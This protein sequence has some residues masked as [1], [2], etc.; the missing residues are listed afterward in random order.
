MKTTKYFII[1]IIAIVCLDQVA[2][3]TLNY[4]HSKTYTGMS[5]GKVNYLIDKFT[6]MPVLA[7]G[8]SRCAHHVIPKV[9]GNER[10]YNLSH[11]GMN[12]IFHAGIIDQLL[13]NEKLKIDTILLHLE[14]NEMFNLSDIKSR[15]IQHLKHYYNDNEWIRN[16][17]T[18][19]SDFEAVKYLLSSYK[20]NG[21]IVSIIMNTIKTQFI[22]PPKD[23][24]VAKPSTKR[25]SINVSW[26]FKTRIFFN[27]NVDINPQFNLHISHIKELCENN[28][29]KL[30]CFMSPNY[31]PN[32]KL[33][34]L[35]KEYKKQFF[36]NLNIVFY[37]YSEEYYTNY[38]LR[39]IWNWTD[40]DHLNEKGALLFSE[41][42][43]KDLYD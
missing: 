7:I 24:Y 12:L 22:L 15:D 19:L 34:K 28:G 4:L 14:A 37:D 43:K 38:R 1:I 41:L 25:D 5:G 31:K 33:L 23:G 30:I 40:C 16:E 8:N 36:D 6:H 21:N 9:I 17:I 35:Q 20:W 27:K 18:E 42:L 39:S 32:K 13:N 26:S 11:N 2:S 10:V 3:N 29:I